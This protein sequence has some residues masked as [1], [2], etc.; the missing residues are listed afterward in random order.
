MARVQA[1]LGLIQAVLALCLVVVLGRAAQVQIVRGGEYAKE[2]ASSRT[3]LRTLEARRGTLYDRS[4]LPMAVTQELYRVG[5]APNEVVERTAL[6]RVAS[7]QLGV[8]AAVVLSAP[9]A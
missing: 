4:G 8:S 2:A 5:I 6:V 3:E 7:R 1:R 9:F